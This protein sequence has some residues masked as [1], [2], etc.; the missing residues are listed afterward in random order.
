MRQAFQLSVPAPAILAAAALVLALADRAASPI[1]ASQQDGPARADADIQLQLGTLLLKDGRYNDAIAAFRRA[2]R[3]APVHLA[4]A[5]TARLVTALLRVGEFEEAFAEADTLVKAEP[6]SAEALS[7]FGDA[8]WALGRFEASENAMRDALALDPNL[9]RA[10]H[11]LSRVLAARS[12]LD[13][14]TV[15]VQAALRAAPTDAEYHYT[16][17]AT[18]QRMK[19]FDAAAGA[20]ENYVNL[21]PNRDKSDKAAWAR[22]QVR[23]LQS[24]E[25]RRPLDVTAG[26]AKVHIVP[27]RL[28]RD[29]V[30]VKARVNDS[31]Y[32]DFTLDTGAEMTIISQR[33]AERVGVRPV[34]YVRSAG[35]GEVGLRGLQVGRIDKLQIGNMMVANVPCLIKNPPLQ[36]MPTRETEAFSPLVL[37]LSMTIDYKLR[38][39]TFGDSLPRQSD[40]ME[41]PL[42][43]HRLA[44]VQGLING[45]HPANFVIDTGGEVI[46]ISQSTVGS[47]RL[48]PEG[49]RIALRVYGTSGWDPDAFLLPNVDLAFEELQMRRMAVVVL[50]LQAPSELLGFQLGGIVGHQ[51]LSK[52]T[53]TIDLPRSTLSLGN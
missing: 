36:G 30:V 10:R 22:A 46:S 21:L 7:V 33:L 42:W 2:R 18:Y 15:E 29:K 41:L 31:G 11:G 25:G 9:P 35:V 3:D 24:F 26:D 27:F 19:A 4:S 13:E 23:F 8:L 51:F 50:N 17:G 43:L 14:A 44:M 34:T 45:A 37:G 1:A 39:L 20:F 47:L 28:V 48:A 5:A 52:Y 12:R 16:L 53:V 38:L 32:T 49:R 40:A 6:H